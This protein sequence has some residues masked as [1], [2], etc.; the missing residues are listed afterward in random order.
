MT[1]IKLV[2]LDG[3]DL[4]VLSA[5]VQDA[6]VRVGELTYLPA[7]KRFVAL[8][9]RFDWMGAEAPKRRTKEN[10]ERRQSGLRI[11]QVERAQL[12]G[13]L[14]GDDKKVLSL[15]AISF[16]ETAPPAGIVTLHFSGDAAVALHVACVEVELKD[17]GAAWA[18]GKRP[19]HPDQ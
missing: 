14:P 12:M 19:A 10:F 7:D 3:E 8:L 13:F 4:A 18:T 9:S 15:L 16:E 11:D 1:D 5:H 17:L 6:I 2:A